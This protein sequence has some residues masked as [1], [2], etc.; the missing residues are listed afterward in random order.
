VPWRNFPIK[1]TQCGDFTTRKIFQNQNYAVRK[2][3]C[4]NYSNT[5]LG[6]ALARWC[7]W[8]FNPVEL[9]QLLGRHADASPAAA[10]AMSQGP[11]PSSSDD[12]IITVVSSEGR[13]REEEKAVSATQQQ[14]FRSSGGGGG[15]VRRPAAAATATGTTTTTTTTTNSKKKQ[16]SRQ[17]ALHHH[18]HRRTLGMGAR[19]AFVAAAICFYLI[20][21]F[22]FF[23]PDP[24]GDQNNLP[25]K[26]PLRMPLP[27]EVPASIQYLRDLYD[28]RHD[29]ILDPPP[30][31]RRSGDGSGTLASSASSSWCASSSLN[32]AGAHRPIPA[33]VLLLTKRRPT[34]YFRQPHDDPT[35][36]MSDEVVNIVQVGLARSPCFSLRNFTVVPDLVLDEPHYELSHDLLVDSAE[37]EPPAHA[38]A[39]PLALLPPMV[40]IV[41]MRRY[42]LVRQ[43]YRG[44]GG[45]YTILDELLELVNNTRNRAR[46]H[47]QKQHYPQQRLRKLVVVLM[48]YRDY[49][50]EVD[51][52]RAMPAIRH[53]VQLLGKNQ[54]R[55]VMQQTVRKRQWNSSLHFVDVGTM[56][57]PRNVS[58]CWGGRSLVHVPYTVRDDVADAVLRIARTRSSTRPVLPT[59]SPSSANPR[60]LQPIQDP[61]FFQSS[62]SW[63]PIDV[64]HMWEYDATCAF[65]SSHAKR[66]R[67]PCELRNQVTLAL[68][69]HFVPPQYKVRTKIAD[70]LGIRTEVQNEYIRTLVA[71]KIVVVSQ[72]DLWEDSYRLMEALVGGAMVLTDPMLTLPM[73]LVDRESI[74]IYQKLEDL[75][76]L[77]D[78]Y[79][80]NE[81]ERIKIARRGHRVALSLHR[82]HHWMERLF[83]GK[84]VT[85]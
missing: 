11:L 46:E 81:A 71:S 36:L 37:E 85:P 8:W 40:W 67:M 34:L 5:L 63:R 14:P 53:L 52:C 24:L 1:I 47:V 28:P 49:I 60:L 29:P 6:C 73:G 54:V 7:R 57:D 19:A 62:S 30:R 23:H 38:A 15:V 26:D 75:P 84:V 43:P 42:Y 77:I 56:Y 22:L 21:R 16:Q 72:R 35:S 32:G 41:D 33:R 4:Q 80:G 74:V 83:F 45:N 79:L 68:H 10:A 48:D 70:S 69:Q 50:P 27:Y 65:S 44:F 2:L 13:N 59:S 18:Q 64:A 9:L 58:E 61:A 78:Y 51:L 20:V 31:G 12:E 66:V 3:H 55:Y 17:G 76:V 39:A 82:P 25:L